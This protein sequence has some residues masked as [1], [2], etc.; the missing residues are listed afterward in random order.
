MLSILKTAD[1]ERCERFYYTYEA[2]PG[3]G[4]FISTYEGFGSPLPSWHG[5]PLCVELT[6]ADAKSL[7]DKLWAS[8]DADNRVSLWVSAGGEE[9]IINK[10]TR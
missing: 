2:K 5:E 9:C 1:G 3:T 8:L 7:A 4:H 6:A 10:E